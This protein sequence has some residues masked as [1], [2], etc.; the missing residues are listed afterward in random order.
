M[1]FCTNCGAAARDRFCGSC[2]AA[3]KIP[4]A[5]VQRKPST[6]GQTQH[7][8][9]ASL[10]LVCPKCQRQVAYPLAGAR[11]IYD[12]ACQFCRVPFRSALAKV[13]GKH[14]RSQNGGGRT[15]SV[16]VYNAA[17]GEELIEFTNSTT[18]DLELRSGDMAV[19][20]YYEGQLSV[21]QNLTISNYL[22][23]SSPRC[24]VA[25]HV[26]GQDSEEVALLRQFRVEVLLD[27]WRL[28]RLVELYYRISPSLI[29]QFGGNHQ[30]TSICRKLLDQL[31]GRL[32]KT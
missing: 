9:T 29:R 10:V 15:F 2:G 12:F 16:R 13:R 6:P 31:V 30:F 5:E 18:Q 20:T 4:A 23:L 21:V 28:V 27:R 32:S 8:T 26:Y 7:T 14:S 19:F 25:T 1:A 11:L 3:I 22:I 24:F 17:G